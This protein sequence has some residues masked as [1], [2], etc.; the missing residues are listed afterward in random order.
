MISDLFIVLFVTMKR[1]HEPLIEPVGIVEDDKLPGEAKATY[2]YA[3][4]CASEMD[5]EEQPT[6]YMT[7]CAPASLALYCHL[8]ITGAVARDREEKFSDMRTLCALSALAGMPG[9]DYEPKDERVDHDL[10]TILHGYDK[11]VVFSI[12]EDEVLDNIMP[13]AGFAMIRYTP[14]F[15]LRGW[16]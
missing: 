13:L 8:A 6:F 15:E 11:L 16:Q 12:V 5:K 3:M 7:M 10:Y 14:V 1:T 4:E 9:Q 2:L